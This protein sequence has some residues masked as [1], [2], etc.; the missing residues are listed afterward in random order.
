MDRPTYL[1]AATPPSSSRKRKQA[2]KSDSVTKVS[3]KKQGASYDN[4]LGEVDN[5]DDV[6]KSKRI[7][8]AYRAPDEKR[9][10]R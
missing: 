7:R 1:V 10:R 6:V 5:V 4:E 8:S 9:L 2:Q 3:N